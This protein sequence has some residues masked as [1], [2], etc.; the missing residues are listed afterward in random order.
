[1]NEKEKAKYALGDIRVLDLADEKGMLCGKILAALG[2][3]VIKVERPG[4]DPA[5]RLSPFYHDVPDPEKSLYWWAF[6]TDKRSITLDIEKPGGQKVLKR[7]VETA[8]FVIE[9]FPPG[10]M[11]KLGLGYPNLSEVNRQIILV[12]ISPFG[13]EGPYRAFKGSDLVV[14]A[15]G[16]MLNQTGDPDRPPLQVSLPQSYIAASTYAAEGVLVALFARDR[17]G[18]G[19]HVDV[20]AMETLAFV[21]SESFPFWY[22]L[23]HNRTRSG[24]RI[25]R[26]GGVLVPQIY[27]CKDGHVN[28]HLQV[29]RPGG[30]RNTRMAQWL[31]EEGLA[32][33]FIRHTDWFQLDWLDFTGESD[34]LTRLTTPLSQLF[35]RYTMKELFDEA[36]KRHI[37][38]YP[39]ASSE[40]TI[41][42]EQLAARNFWVSL[43]HP[44]IGETI[45][46]PG[47]FAVLTETPVQINQRA[48]LIGEHNEEI[49]LTELGISKKEFQAMVEAK[50]I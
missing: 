28:Y 4:G 6:N 46:Y 44:E 12:S 14:W 33:D 25:L 7:L 8:D 19:Q 18:E 47:A 43:E 38:L 11:D 3:D 31:E 34:G 9:S 39:V 17:L 5:R 23:G 1:L 30:E 26:M 22:A 35:A 10:Y 40:D 29:G 13:Q 50:V 41:K 45:T 21:G 27:P 32:T 36:F 42:N 24:S 37:S 16:G 15:L 2:A 49:Y 20:S 48:P